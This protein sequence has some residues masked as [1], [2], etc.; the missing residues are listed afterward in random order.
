MP[1][2]RPEDLD[3]LCTQ[4]AA[5]GDVKGWMSLFEPGAKLPDP[6]GEEKSGDALREQ[7]AS[8]AAMKPEFKMNITKVVQAGDIALIHNEWSIPALSMS[9]YAVEVARRQPDGTW[10]LVIDDPFTIGPRA[11]VPAS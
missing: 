11:S 3:Q 2:N 1:A 4:Y 6:E 8:L 5:S 7:L 9:G 10:L